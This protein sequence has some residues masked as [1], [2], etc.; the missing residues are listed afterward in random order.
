MADVREREK[1]TREIEKMSES[2]RKKHRALKTGRI[3]EDI[4]LD[5]HFKPIIKPMQ[6]II[7]S[8]VRAIKRQ[9]RR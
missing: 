3:E 6:Q 2:I 4:S 7:D 1:I 5:R 8:F 9:L